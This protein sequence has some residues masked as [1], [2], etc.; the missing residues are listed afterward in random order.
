MLKELLHQKKGS[1]SQR[2]LSAIG[3]TTLSLLSLSIP[4]SAASLTCNPKESVCQ[5]DIYPTELSAD[6][7]SSGN[8]LAPA[9]TMM[10]FTGTKSVKYILGGLLGLT[11]LS[12]VLG[13]IYQAIGTERDKTKYLPPGKL[14]EVKGRQFHLYCTGEGSPT[15][16]MDYGIGGLSPVWSLVQPEVAKFTRVCSYDR[17]GY[18]WSESSPAPR[19]SQQMVEELHA[20]LHE[21]GIEGPYVLVGHS[22]GGLNAR[23]FASQYPEEVV[24]LVLVDAVP[25]E[26]YSRLATA[27]PEAMSGLRKKF[28]SLVW[29]ARLGLLRLSIQLKGAAAAP[30][31][32]QK[33][34][35]EVQPKIL[36]QFLPKTFT[37]AIAENQ[38]M[39]NSAEQVRQAEFIKNLPLV[40]LSHGVNMF[41]D[42]SIKEPDQAESIWQELQKSMANLSSD[43]TF[44]IVKSSGHD[45]HIYQPQLV[46]DAIH[47]VVEKFRLRERK[48]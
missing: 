47:Q 36:S 32:I 11:L 27:W 19:T 39:E 35:L 21:A 9:L 15:V 2:N 20:L 40:V 3:L 43:S 45:I 1:R 28:T 38:L 14:V 16:V 29:I 10:T 41:V 37:T 23:L 33:L 25:A 6:K 46:V 31:F 24:G 42:L 18:G 30:D 48:F 17:A 5:K 12:V 13:I 7:A 4:V 34:P 44:Q 8:S 22:L 26:I